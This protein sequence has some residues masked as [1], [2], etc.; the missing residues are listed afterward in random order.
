MA[1]WRAIGSDLGFA[2]FLPFTL[3]IALSS[4]FGFYW[5]GYEGNPLVIAFGLSITWV[6]LLIMGLV[7]YGRWTLVML[8][9]APFALF[10]PILFILAQF[11]SYDD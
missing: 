3:F 2:I 11:V 4:T 5:I 8:F 1:M 9:G 7:V 6:L 10:W